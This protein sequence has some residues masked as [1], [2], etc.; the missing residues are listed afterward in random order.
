[1]YETGFLATAKQYTPTLSGQPF[2]EG[3]CWPT[4]LFKIVVPELT[5][6]E[7]TAAATS[8]HVN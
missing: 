2:T 7:L 5:S 6:T 8:F 1:M 3:G 4:L